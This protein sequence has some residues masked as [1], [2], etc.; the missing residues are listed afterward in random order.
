MADLG[1]ISAQL[2]LAGVQRRLTSIEYAGT[3]PDAAPAVAM[4]PPP[5]VPA[6]PAP[7]IEPQVI[8]IEELGLQEVPKMWTWIEADVR[9]QSYGMSMWSPLLL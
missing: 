8:T 4:A 1:D 6:S 2:D 3:D 7:S 5:P 9:V